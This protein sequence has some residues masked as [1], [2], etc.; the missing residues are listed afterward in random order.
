MATSVRQRTK[1]AR[2]SERL[3]VSGFWGLGFS[4]V[5]LGVWCFKVSST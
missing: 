4:V 2:L 3:F 5:G 1:A